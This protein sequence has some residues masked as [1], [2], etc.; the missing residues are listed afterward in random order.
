MIADDFDSIKKALDEIQKEKPAKPGY[1]YDPATD[2]FIPDD[3]GLRPGTGNS[4]V[5]AVLTT[6]AVSGGGWANIFIKPAPTGQP[7]DA[8]QAPQQATP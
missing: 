3:H 6:R 5:N 4:D 2:S 7:A 8:Q 1:V